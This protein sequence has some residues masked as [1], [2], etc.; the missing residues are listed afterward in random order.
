VIA[1]LAPVAL[2][3]AAGAVAENLLEPVEHLREALIARAPDQRMWWL[4]LAALP[5]AIF[6][7]VAAVG[8][9]PDEEV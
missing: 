3:L 8:D 5:I 1:A 9:R 2:F 4:A 6:A 7:L